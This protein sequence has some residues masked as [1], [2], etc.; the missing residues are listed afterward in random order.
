MRYDVCDFGVIGDG[1]T[2]NTN[3]IKNLIE[4]ICENGGE[5][6]FP[7]GEYI[8]GT[9]RLFDNMSLYLEKGAKILGS[10]DFSDYPKIDEK[11]VPGYTRCGYSGLITA[12]GC[13]NIAICGEGEIDGR[14]YNWWQKLPSDT[15][16]PRAINPILCK[17]V[18]ISGITVKNSPCWS[19]HPMCCE[20]V[21]IENVSVINP[22]DSPNTD[23]INPESCKNVRISGCYIDVGDD[24]ITIKSG[25]EDDI[26]QKSHPSVNILVE[27]CTMKH[28]HGGVVIGSEMSGGVKDVTVRNCT[29]SETDRGIRLKTRRKRGGY[30]ENVS[31]CDIKMDA[32]LAAVTFNEYYICGANPDDVELF[33]K[34]KMPVGAYT[35]KISGVTIRDIKA[36]DVKGAGIYMYG[37]PEAPLSD[38]V[39]ENIDISVRGC[40]EGIDAVMA[41]NRTKSYG[42]G[43][44]MENA[45]NVRINN[46]AITCP[47][48][49]ITVK[50]CREVCINGK[51][52]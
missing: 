39:M 15:M 38:I 40:A 50:N 49:K 30:V 10:A 52:I 9:I 17:N 22:P 4:K 23:G 29:F 6:Y 12:I 41:P 11:E 28:G 1:K 5:L 44:F 46:I 13:K 14:G 51:N 7:E 3:A 33:S 24:C 18:T 37:L 45:E 43:I 31:F 47:E 20:N 8:T 25:T 21:L 27:N 32:V 16:R 34:E 26:L 36:T 19:V 42:E 2:N 35:P 48:E